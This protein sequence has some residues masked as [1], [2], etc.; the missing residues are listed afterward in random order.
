MPLKAAIFTVFLNASTH[1]EEDVE[2][3]EGAFEAR[4]NLSHV[5]K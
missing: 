4:V 3:G 5:C 1:R 2:D